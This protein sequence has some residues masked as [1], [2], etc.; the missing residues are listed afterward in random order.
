[1]PKYNITERKEHAAKYRSLVNPELMDELKEKIFQ[2]IVI[3]GKYKDKD[4]SARDLA[5]DLGTN[6]RYVSA[7][8]NVKFHTNYPGFVNR[9]RIEEAM[10]L[11]VDKR[12]LTYT[13]EQI[14]DMVG[15]A[16][17]QSFYSSFYRIT[18]MSPRLYRKTY[19]DKH[20]VLQ[21]ELDLQKFEK[22][23]QKKLSKQ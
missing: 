12:Y 21:H 9:Y 6:T 8:I 13:M 15:F 7:V 23:R 1:M 19:L 10:S 11:M 5:R 18:E 20:P 14:S 17:R 2:I 4:Y 22:H 3:Q 16:N